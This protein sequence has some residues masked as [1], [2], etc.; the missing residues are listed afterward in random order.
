[1]RESE[2]VKGQHVEGTSA[3]PP[4]FTYESSVPEAV[5]PPP[6]TPPPP[7]QAAPPM[8]MPVPAGFEV[9][10]EA[11]GALVQQL[12]M[13]VSTGI[14][15][16]DA[17]A[18]ELVGQLGPAPTAAIL[19]NMS[20]DTLCDNLAAS[21]GGVLATHEGRTYMRKLWDEAGKIVGTT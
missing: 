16:P 11:V 21:K 8:A 12:E 19:R 10:P 17:F 9:S 13:A 14:V 2:P 7:P 3:P 5:A 4:P 6:P 18:K 1:M 15:E 20:A